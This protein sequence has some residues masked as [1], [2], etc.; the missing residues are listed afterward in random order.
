MCPRSRGGLCRQEQWLDLTEGW[1]GTKSARKALSS[2]WA[3]EECPGGLLAA[4]DAY[5]VPRDGEDKMPVRLEELKGR[6]RECGC[7]S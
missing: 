1:G 7:G 6:V 2:A 4:S 3:K 5:R